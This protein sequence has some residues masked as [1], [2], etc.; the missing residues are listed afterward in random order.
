MPCAGSLQSTGFVGCDGLLTWRGAGI[1]GAPPP[2]F[3][4]PPLVPQRQTATR[5]SWR[6]QSTE[7]PARAMRGRTCQSRICDLSVFRSVS[8]RY[9]GL[10][11]TAHSAVAS[12]ASHHL[13]YSILNTGASRPRFSWHPTFKHCRLRAFTDCSLFVQ[14]LNSSRI[15][16]PSVSGTTAFRF[17][18]KPNLPLQ[19]ADLGEPG[20]GAVVRNSGVRVRFPGSRL[21]PS[22][23]TPRFAPRSAPL[24]LGPFHRAVL[25]VAGLAALAP[26]RLHDDQLAVASPKN[27]DTRRDQ[28][29]RHARWTQ[30]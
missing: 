6:W 4:F 8:T 24:P 15:S 17:A 9:L 19:V 30:R 22:R 26:S 13:T 23:P 25:D 20:P 16:S 5:V 7:F 29:G 18:M 14:V 21:A 28:Y 12:N 1:T 10:G 27:A 11:P 2:H 3:V